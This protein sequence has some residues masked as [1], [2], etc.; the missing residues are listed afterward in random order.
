MEASGS[1]ERTMTATA[2]PAR[3]RMLPATSS[4]PLH[5]PGR[6][7]R[8]EC[9]VLPSGLQDVRG[10]ARR[11]PFLRIPVK[12]ELGQGRQPLTFPFPCRLCA[13]SSSILCFCACSRGALANAAG[14]WFVKP[15]TETVDLKGYAGWNALLDH[16]QI[17]RLSAQPPKQDRGFF[18]LW[19]S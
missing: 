13:S 12:T 15:Q 18:W 3:T 14:I 10:P 9:S 4:R 7:A 8:L 6:G 16:C 2:L 17:A 11:A 19:R 1:R 5:H